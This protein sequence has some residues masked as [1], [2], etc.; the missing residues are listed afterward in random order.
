MIISKPI[1]NIRIN[2]E[3]RDKL[4]GTYDKPILINITSGERAGESLIFHFKIKEN[5]YQYRMNKVNN[6]SVTLICA[7]RYCKCSAKLRLDS[8]FPTKIRSF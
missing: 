5:Y 7:H 8:Q 6:G 4:D 1:D 3:N 2:F